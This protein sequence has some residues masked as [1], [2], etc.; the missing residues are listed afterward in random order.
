MSKIVATNR[1]D[2][3]SEALIKHIIYQMRGG[4][5][6]P[7]LLTRLGSAAEGGAAKRRRKKKYQVSLEDIGGGPESEHY[8]SIS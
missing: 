5:L 4:D 1:G 7:A 2:H 6:P 8:K 3:L